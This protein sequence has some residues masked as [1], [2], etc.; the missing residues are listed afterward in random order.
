MLQMKTKNY[1]RHGKM[2]QE[3]EEKGTL[4]LKLYDE[5]GVQGIQ[6]NGGSVAEQPETQ[7]MLQTVKSETNI[8]FSTLQKRAVNRLQLHQSARRSCQS[9]STGPRAKYLGAVEFR[10]TEPATFVTSRHGNAARYQPQPAQGWMSLSR[11]Q[12]L[13]PGPC[14]RCV[15]LLVPLHVCRFV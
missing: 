11:D 9:I 3:N 4:L 5:H 2:F 6:V 10:Q 15:R 1:T 14:G 8:A 12:P 7:Y 13:P